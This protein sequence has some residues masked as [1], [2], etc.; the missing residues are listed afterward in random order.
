MKVLVQR[1]LKAKVEV[2]NKEVSK[3]DKGLILYVGFSERDDEEV[4]KKMAEKIINLRIFEDE[5]GLMNLA[6]SK[7]KE[8]LSISQFTLYGDT[9]KGNRPSFKEALNPKDAKVLYDL[10]NEELNKYITVK[11]GVFQADMKVTTV[12]DGPLS[13]I[14]EK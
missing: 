9:K 1:V 7:D 5:Q 4:V 11:R 2:G 14:L 12:V 8:I 10:F 13:I 3:I 6:I